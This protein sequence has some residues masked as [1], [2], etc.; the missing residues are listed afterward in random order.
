MASL[1]LMDGKYLAQARLELSEAQ[2][3]GVSR[4]EH[5][6]RSLV[7][8]TEAFTELES[9]MTRISAGPPQWSPQSKTPK[10]P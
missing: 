7:A 10:N 6:L 5:T 3:E 1:P 9:R 8:L 2:A 4:E